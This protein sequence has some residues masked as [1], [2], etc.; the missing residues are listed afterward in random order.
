MKTFI[1]KYKS[2]FLIVLF[3]FSYSTQLYSQNTT[4]DSAKITISGFVDMY[5]SK[6]FA[7]P[8]SRINKYR[9]FDINENQFSLSLAELVVEK[10][11]SPVGFRMDLDFGTTT[12]LV[13]TTNGVVNETIKHL[14]QAFL[15][16]VL[17][18]GNG[19]T[20]NAGKMVTHMGREV[21]ESQ[22]NNNY[23]RSLL[24]AYAIPYYHVGIMFSYPFLNNLSFT[25]YIYNGWNR[26]DDNNSEKTFGAS[27]VWSPLN[28]L[29][30]IENVIAGAEESNTN[31]KRY[32][33]D[34][35]LNFAVSDDLLFIINADYGFER[36]LTNEL[37]VW[38]GIAVGSKY[39]IDEATAFAIRA[40]IYN[41]ISGF[42]T[43]ISQ[44][45][46]EITLTYEYKFRS[47]LL[48]RFEYRTDWSDVY[49]FDSRN[50]I[51]N[52]KSQNTLLIGSVIS[53]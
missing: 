7:N 36:L 53:F 42:T 44:E 31:N 46:K 22:L 28:N 32:V 19:L 40:E 17:P 26:I 39:I 30:I 3:V 14:Q 47:N 5:Y 10:Q 37:A 48:L 33:F 25:G 52:K 2:I 8:A 29:T 23:S 20:I 45:L 49:S 43:G 18:I 38:K 12:D 50:G 16:I 35:I 4:K 6:N 41:D 51:N 13:H 9:N 21:I 24:F 15:T 34:S 1:N 11:P 27:I